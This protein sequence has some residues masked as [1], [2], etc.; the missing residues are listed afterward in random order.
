MHRE[1]TAAKG[2][3]GSRDKRVE[4]EGEEEEDVNGDGRKRQAAGAK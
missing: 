4:E 2:T 1:G 3:G